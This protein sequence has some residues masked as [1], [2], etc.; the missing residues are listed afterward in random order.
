[1]D[2]DAQRLRFGDFE[3]DFQSGK[4]TREGRIVKIQP[5]PL[6]VLGILATRSGELVSR[7]ELRAQIWDDATFVEFDQGLNYCVRQIRLALHDNATDPVYVETLPKQGYRFI[8]PVVSAGTPSNGQPQ[9]HAAA[10]SPATD[11]PPRSR[12]RHGSGLAIAAVLFAV[13]AGGIWLYQR[14]GK[15][16]RTPRQAALPVQQLTDFA[17]SAVAP[18]LSPDGRMIAFIRSGSN[19]MT[20]DQIYVK[21]LPDGEP[22]RL[23][24]DPRLKYGP[25]FSPDGSQVAY[26]V[27][28]HSGWSTYA[29]PVLGGEPKLILTNAAG[30]TWLDQHRLLFSQIQAGQHMG[31][32]TGTETRANLRELYFPPHE[33]G[34]AHYSFPS[35]DRSSALVVEMNEKPAWLPCRLISLDGRFESRPVGPRGACTS[36]GWSPDGQWMY[37]AASVDGASHL[38][39]QRFPDG[40]PEQLTFGPAEEQDVAVDRDGRSL[41]TSIGFQESTLWIHQAGGDRPLSSEG[42]VVASEGL[43]TIPS[44]S[45]DNQFVY[46]LLRRASEGSGQELRRLTVKTGTSEVVFPGISILEYDVSPD[47]RQV[48]YATAMPGGKSQLWL[49]PVDKSSP[50]KPIGLSGETSPYFGPHGEILFR[51]TEGKFNY[52]ARMNPDGSGRSKVVPYPISTVQGVS[53]GRHWVMAIAPLL[54]NSTVAPMAIPVDG[55]NPVRICEIFCETGWT[56]NGEFVFASVEEPSLSSP[57]RSLAIPVGPGEALPKFPPSGI[58]PRADASV[59]PGARSVKGAGLVPGPD[60]ATFVYVKTSVHRN[61]FR[62]SLP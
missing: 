43:I 7:E 56:T 4:L 44:F 61:L 37:F 21:M 34:M 6:R 20:P 46:Y 33:R 23:T 9:S 11:V 45:R 50:P 54:D 8:A 38:W 58:S 60:P 10:S 39:R 57:G 24:N 2:R 35:P 15:K 49:A 59:I 31:I 19:F 42:Q 41:I 27:M 28:E 48:V 29:V 51:L 12:F 40:T 13:L 18:A 3:L 52:L 36:A 30:L 26:T 47:G 55:G 62:I 16:P 25:A 53:P 5:Q 22:K 32:V 14:S 17:D 1:M